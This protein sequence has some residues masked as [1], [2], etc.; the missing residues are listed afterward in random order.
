MIRDNEW[1]VVVDRQ[2]VFAESDW[3]TWAVPDG[4]YYATN[5]NFAKLA[6]AFGDRVVYTKY[7]SPEPPQD[8]WADYFADWPDFIVPHTDP[9]FD[10]TDDTAPLVPGHPVV[11]CDTFSKWGP[12]L[13]SAINDSRRITVCGVATDF[14]VLQTALAACDAGI[15]VRIAADACAGTSPENHRLA[16][17]LMSLYAPLIAVTDTATIVND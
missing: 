1:L 5:D 3:S 9:M 7:V 6:H 10:W 8:A 4:S 2:K 11:T 17:D 12:D 15:S 13:A 16:L 14:C